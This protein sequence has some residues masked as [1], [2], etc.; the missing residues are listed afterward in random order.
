MLLSFHDGDGE[1]VS[2]AGPRHASAEH[3][4]SFPTMA[5]G[6]DVV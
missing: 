5:K 6:E 4:P 2:V 3:Q 1:L